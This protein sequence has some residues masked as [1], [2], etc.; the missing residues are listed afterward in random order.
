MAQVNGDPEELRAFARKL[1]NY[2]DAIEEETSSLNAGFLQLGD[3]WQ[4]GK[5]QEYEETHEIL[6]ASIAAFRDNAEEQVPY[7]NR[8][9]DDLDTYLGR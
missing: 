8:L 3:S 2:L 5:R 7:L 1:Q 6:L 4:D 9:A